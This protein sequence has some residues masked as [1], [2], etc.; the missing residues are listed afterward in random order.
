METVR[1]GTSSILLRKY[2]SIYIHVTESEWGCFIYNAE[3]NTV[4][5]TKQVA[6]LN[7]T[8]IVEIDAKTDRDPVEFKKIQFATTW[9]AELIPKDF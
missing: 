9:V 4:Y 8:S 3:D 7:G 1:K 6:I 5:S 2:P